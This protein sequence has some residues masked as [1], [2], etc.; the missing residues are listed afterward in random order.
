MKMKK[1]YLVALMGDTPPNAHT[2]KT[3]AA[4]AQRIGVEKGGDG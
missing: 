2:L 1:V 4:P 3:W